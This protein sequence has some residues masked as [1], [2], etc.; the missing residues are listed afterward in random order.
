M[1]TNYFQLA[2]SWQNV[3]DGDGIGVSLTGMS[4]VF[5]GLVLISL[6]IA[7]IPRLFAFFDYR[8][9]AGKLKAERKAQK[10]VKKEKSDSQT[11]SILEGDPDLAAAI[12]FV[13]RS[14]YEYSTAEDHQRITIVR[15]ADQSI[16]AVAGK[17]RSL[18]S[19]ARNIRK[20][21]RF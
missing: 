15:D 11:G 2:L 17:M 12:A 3:L 18:S 13:L 10:T 5:S 19:Q 8:I 7:G 6:Y 16:W 4:I 9:E 20:Q 1:S 14:E 21:A